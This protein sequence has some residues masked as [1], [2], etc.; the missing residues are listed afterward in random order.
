MF[1]TF[2]RIPQRF[3]KN[4]PEVLEESPKRSLDPTKHSLATFQ[5]FLA[6]DV[7]T[8]SESPERRTSAPTC[9]AIP[10]ELSPVGMRWGPRTENC[11]PG[12]LI[13]DHRSRSAAATADKSSSS[14]VRTSIM[15][16]SFWMRP[17][18][19]GLRW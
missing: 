15:K 5:T 6:G 3:L 7:G 16:R 10:R 18:L 19:G 14:S 8:R 12:L 17:T 2:L 9:F 13:T 1:A 4:L 11:E